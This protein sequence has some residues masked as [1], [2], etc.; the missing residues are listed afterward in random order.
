MRRLHLPLLER[1]R[2]AHGVARGRGQH[3][4][5]RLDRLHRVAAHLVPR[6]QA[7][8]LVPLARVGH[9]DL[10]VPAEDADA[11]HADTRRGPRLAH[12]RTAPRRVLG[13]PV[14]AGIGEILVRHG[15]DLGGR[16]LRDVRRGLVVHPPLA[17]A[18]RRLLLRFVRGRRLLPRRQV[19]RRNRARPCA[20]DLDAEQRHD[21]AE[22]HVE[23]RPASH[24]VAPGLA[25]GGPGGGGAGAAPP[26]ASLGGDSAGAPSPPPAAASPSA[27]PAPRS[28]SPHAGA[29]SGALAPHAAR[30]YPTAPPVADR[31]RGPFAP[32]TAPRRF[33]SRKGMV[34]CCGPYSNPATK[35]TNWRTSPMS[36][37]RIDTLRK[38]SAGSSFITCVLWI[39]TPFSDASEL[40]RSCSAAAPSVPLPAG[41]RRVLA[42][43]R[44]WRSSARSARKVSTAPMKRAARSSCSWPSAISSATRR[45]ESTIGATVAR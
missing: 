11:D 37:R 30:R 3:E 33:T 22:Q 6:P 19:D 39:A 34:S 20:H 27:V 14:A 25:S 18:V 24:Q 8:L 36:V 32:G 7:P 45:R 26:G 44:R 41:S 2:H 28:P 17:L 10:A 16:A 43:V 9:E 35:S 23:N 42:W 4:L 40:A 5:G 15:G 12:H 21:H 13:G 29:T 38:G 31:V 1:E